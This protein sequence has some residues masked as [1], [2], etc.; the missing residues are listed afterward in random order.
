[1]EIN[2][3][4][5]NQLIRMI[6][7]GVLLLIFVLIPREIVF[8][9][10]HLVCIH[11]YLLGFQCPL[12]G[13]TRAVYEFIHFRFQSAIN[14]NPVIIMLPLYF[15]SDIGTAFL[16]QKWLKTTKRLILVSILAGL[17]V[18]YLFRLAHHFSCS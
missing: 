18:L 7:I 17:L 1:M 4:P 13:M 2:Q 5:K 15:V 6:S 12:C 14:Y 11:Y 10:T 16:P 3:I 8:D 9:K